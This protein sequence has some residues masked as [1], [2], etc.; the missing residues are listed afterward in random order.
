MT[1]PVAVGQMRLY[2]S[3]RPGLQAGSYEVAMNQRFSGGGAATSG[4]NVP[5]DMSVDEVRKHFDVTGPQF[6]LSPT[7]V[8]SVFPPNNAVGPFHNQLPH[9]A[10]GRRT[11]P[12]ERAGDPARPDRPWLALVVLADGEANFVRNVDIGDVVP[13]AIAAGAQGT[14]DMLEVSSTVVEQVF[15]REDE[16]E[17][18]LHV[19]QVNVNDTENAGNDEDGFMAVV[20]ANRL[21][22]SGHAYGAY[23]ISIEGRFG[24]L[25]DPNRNDFTDD[26]AKFTV[27]ELSDAQLA[28]ASYS[29]G[30]GQRP[31]QFEATNHPTTLSDL[32]GAATTSLT[33]RVETRTGLGSATRTSGW[34]A[35]SGSATQTRTARTAAFGSTTVV[36]DVDFSVF[37]QAAT[38]LRFPVLAHWQ[39]TCT[40]GLDFRQLMIG[41]DVAMLGSRPESG[42]EERFPVVADTGHTQIAHTTRAGAAGTAWYRG[43]FTPREVARRSRTGPFHSA[44]QA[45]TLGGDGMEN[46]GEAAAFE[47][48]RMLAL[49]DP[50]FLQQLL[51]WRRDGFRLL[52]TAGVLDLLDLGDRFD[53]FGF[54]GVA[55]G[56]AAGILA[57]LANDDA[58]RLG[59]R[60]DPAFGIPRFDDDAQVIA[61]G[62]GTSVGRVRT[63]LGIGPD[64]T[65][66]GV[67]IGSR[68]EPDVTSFDALLESADE[69]LAHLRGDLDRTVDRIVRRA[70][71]RDDVRRNR[72]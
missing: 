16:L 10:L 26:L 46:L 23:L 24:D 55:R 37:D 30:G 20:M 54:A 12:W 49:A 50:S 67:A 47:V 51:R 57:G 56:V 7:E 71:P 64:L 29:A 21:P 69:E 25:P 4:I 61:T 59:P 52:K 19:R 18:L 39:F 38:L 11:L 35:A 53:G 62:L 2:S 34:D 28:A 22:Q 6:S 58:A 27:Y 66:P 44:D 1:D 45:R 40:D 8:H 36:H 3:V 43:P 33:S 15:P 65:T 48:G 32:G 31:V 9:I 13:P 41:L 14:C 5:T 68:P 60:I 17:Y 70:A 63:A 42:D 72:G